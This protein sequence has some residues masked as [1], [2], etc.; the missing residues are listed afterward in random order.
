MGCRLLRW[1]APLVLAVCG[2]I[3]PAFADD[4]VTN[5]DLHPNAG[6]GILGPAPQT[7][8]ADSSDKAER[9]APTFQIFMAVAAA[10]IVLCILCAPS[11]KAESSTAR[12]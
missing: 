1:V 7:A 12:R 4:P 11:R 2:A 6:S 8:P 10:V 5:K 3:F 9:P